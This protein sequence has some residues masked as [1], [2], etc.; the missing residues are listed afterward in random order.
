MLFGHDATR[1]GSRVPVGRK[2]TDNI[3]KS[4]A[5]CTRRLK[6]SVLWKT[7]LSRH[8]HTHARSDTVTHIERGKPARSAARLRVDIRERLGGYKCSSA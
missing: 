6:K 2:F 1:R 7:C 4:G 3:I 5:A 8:V